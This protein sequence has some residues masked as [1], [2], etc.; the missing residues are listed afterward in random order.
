MSRVLARTSMIS[1]ER[2]LNAATRM[3]IDSTTNITTR[4]TWSASNKAEFIERQSLTIARLATAAGER[5]QDL[6]RPGRHR[7]SSTSIMP[8][9]S[10]IIRK[11]CASS[12]GMTTNALSKS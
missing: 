2:M 5:R 12:I 10:P 7:R 9:A 4:S 8:T 11:F 6:A 3:M 1:E